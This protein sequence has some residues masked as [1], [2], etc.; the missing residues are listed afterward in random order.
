MTRRV[1]AVPKGAWLLQTAGGSQLGR[2]VIRLGIDSGFRTLS[3]VR[4]PEQAEELRELGGGTALA[5]D[6][7][8]DH[9]EDFARQVRKIVGDE[10]VRYAIDPVGGG[11][12]SA[13]VPCLGRGGRMLVYGTLAD[14]SLIFDSRDLMTP[15]ASIEGFWLTNYMATLGLVSKVSLVSSITGLVKKGVLASEIG[16]VF[17]LDDVGDAVEDAERPARGGK[18]LIRIGSA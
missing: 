11:T 16:H 12:G 7:E 8:R 6:P 1:L 14:G 5:F 3:V 17:E 15:G 13:V 2:M 4:R 10:G 18:T 9:A